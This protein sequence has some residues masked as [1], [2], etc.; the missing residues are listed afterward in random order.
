MNK[1]GVDMMIIPEDDYYNYKHIKNLYKAN[2]HHM[3][4]TFKKGCLLA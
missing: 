2:I 4:L 1:K 3:K